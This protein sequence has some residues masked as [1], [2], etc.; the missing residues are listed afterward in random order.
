MRLIAAMSLVITIVGPV[1]AQPGNLEVK[2]EVLREVE[3][4]AADGSKILQIKPAGTILP[5]HEV[6]YLTTVK[7]I[8]KQPAE[9]VVVDNPIPEHTRF[10]SNSTFGQGTRLEASVDGGKQ[11]ARFESLQV[12]AADGSKRAAEARDVTNLRFILTE[13]LPPGSERRVGFRAILQ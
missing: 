13:A 3:T 6:I 12:T 11:F 8:G 4:I 9:N 7:N 10:K 5:G 1:Q 2:N